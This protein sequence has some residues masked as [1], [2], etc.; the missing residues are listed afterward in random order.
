MYYSIVDELRERNNGRKFR[1]GD[2]VKYLL[3]PPIYDDDYFK[4]PFVVKTAF[5]TPQV[6]EA[7]G[8]LSNKTSYFYS[9]TCELIEKRLDP[10]DKEYK[11]LFI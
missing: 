1:V 3:P 7:V 6:I 2:R 9:Y 5:G 8:E 10:D 11:E 4:Q